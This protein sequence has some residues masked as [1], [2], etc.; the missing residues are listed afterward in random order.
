MMDTSV[1]GGS[2]TSAARATKESTSSASDE[3]EHSMQRINSLFTRSSDAKRKSEG[4]EARKR[5]PPTFTRPSTGG[6]LPPVSSFGYKTPNA[7]SSASLVS[8]SSSTIIQS[9][10][11]K[12]KRGLTAADRA[13]LNAMSSSNKNAEIDLRSLN[14]HLRVRVLEI[15]GCSEAMWD[16]VKE[17]QHRELE[18]E[19]KRKEQLALAARKTVQG[20]GGGRVSYYHR[21]RVKT[22]PGRDRQNSV[23]SDHSILNRK[24]SAKSFVSSTNGKRRGGDGDSNGDGEGTSVKA[25]GSVIES[26]TSSFTTSL[27][28]VRGDDLGEHLEKSVKQELLRMTR[29]RFDEILSWFQL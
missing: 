11:G 25:P 19:R 23:G 1:I 6:S 3:L 14:L 2:W 9:D 24:K 8:S 20:V 12:G 26:P 16:W 22:N 13:Q 21:D 27:G 7:T 10:S 4:G 5:L 18:K 15:L 29:E 17:F 28:S